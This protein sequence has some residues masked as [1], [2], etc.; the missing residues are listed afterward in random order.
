M[1][2]VLCPF[3]LRRWGVSMPL[4][5]LSVCPSDQNNFHN[6][7]RMRNGDLDWPLVFER[8]QHYQIEVAPSAMQRMQVQ[9][10]RW[11][12]LRAAHPMLSL[13]D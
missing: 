5:P 4:L 3:C 8:L 9:S 11:R 7:T 13:S 10:V 1:H 2:G 12:L 6:M